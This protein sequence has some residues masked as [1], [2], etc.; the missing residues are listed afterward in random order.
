MK[1]G[2]ISILVGSISAMHLDGEVVAAYSASGDDGG[3]VCETGGDG[4]GFWQHVCNDARKFH[5]LIYRPIFVVIHAS[6]TS[7]TV[8][9]ANQRD[10][11]RYYLDVRAARREHQDHSDS[12]AAHP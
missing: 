5:F 6:R 9:K 4:V 2:S 7:R 1:A 11:I 8:I 3:D 12:L 10:F